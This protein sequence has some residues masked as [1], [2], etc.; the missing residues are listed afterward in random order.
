LVADL[1]ASTKQTATTDCHNVA[2]IQ[3]GALKVKTHN[4]HTL[5]HSNFITY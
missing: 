1:V 2:E 4:T 3:G 5:I